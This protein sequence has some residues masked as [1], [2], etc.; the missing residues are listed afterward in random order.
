M[1]QA[2]LWLAKVTVCVNSILIFLS[3]NY[4]NLHPFP[5]FGFPDRSFCQLY[6]SMHTHWAWCFFIFRAFESEFKEDVRYSFVLFMER[7]L[8]GLPVKSQSEVSNLTSV[9]LNGVKYLQLSPDKHVSM[10][11]FRDIRA[12]N[13]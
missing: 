11:P 3:L 2:M 8:G 12:G 7:L 5:S 9:H 1:N 13:H 10:F 6:F 4:P